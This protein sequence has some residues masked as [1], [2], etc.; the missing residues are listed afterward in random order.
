MLQWLHL[1]Q[2]YSDFATFLTFS[3]LFLLAINFRKAFLSSTLLKNA[4]SLF[5]LIL[6]M[7][8]IHK[9]FISEEFFLM[10][11][12]SFFAHNRSWTVLTVFNWCFCQ[13]IFWHWFDNIKFC[14][15]NQVLTLIFFRGWG[16]PNKN[17]PSN[18]EGWLM[19]NKRKGSQMI[20]S[21][22][23]WRLIPLS[24]FH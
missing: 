3:S 7:I 1:F 4:K 8:E 12:L 10:V 9:N 24:F 18:W 2:S 19:E 20:D 13:N 16:C 15:K 21:L 6:L 23:W 14:I 5:V 17:T 22:S 11:R